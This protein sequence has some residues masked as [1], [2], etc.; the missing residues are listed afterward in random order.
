MDKEPPKTTRLAV[1]TV[2]AKLYPTILIP[3]L[4]RRLIQPGSS[5]INNS[6]RLNRIYP[7]GPDKSCHA[8]RRY[9]SPETLG[10]LGSQVDW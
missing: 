5:W 10:V 7:Q 6:I 1:K 2:I 8:A 9:L 3:G 4:N